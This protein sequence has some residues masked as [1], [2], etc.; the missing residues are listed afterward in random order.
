MYFKDTIRSCHL[1][2]LQPNFPLEV[3]QC[4]FEMVS[5]AYLTRSW[6]F[7]LCAE[8]HSGPGLCPTPKYLSPDAN[9]KWPLAVLKFLISGTYMRE[10]GQ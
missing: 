10:P 6:L 2:T 7:G 9:Q 3:A 1:C 4:H 5:N 8:F